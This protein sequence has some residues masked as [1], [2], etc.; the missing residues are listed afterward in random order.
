MIS[1]RVVSPEKTLFFGVAESITL[2]TENGEIQVLPGHAESFF[3]LEKGEITLEIKKKKE[4]ISI[5][6]GIFHIAKDN[7]VSIVSI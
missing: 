4:K 7:A 5:S 2:P 6:K 1:Y 3:I